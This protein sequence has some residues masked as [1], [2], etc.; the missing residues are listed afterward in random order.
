MKKAM[1]ILAAVLIAASA[2]AGK[3]LKVLAIGNSFSEDAVEQYLYELAAA[4][5]DSLVIGNAYIGGC[6]IDR[7]WSNAQSRKKEYRYRKIIGGKTVTRK[8]VDLA[9]IIR[10]DQWDIISLQQVSYLTGMPYSFGNLSNLKDYVLKTC[11]NPEVEIIWH[12]TWAYARTSG[13]NGFR[14]Y[15]KDQQIMYNNILLTTR[16]RVPRVGIR[17]VVPAGMAIQFARDKMGDVL[18]RDGFHLEKTYGRYTA[19]CTW[20][21]V[22]TRRKVTGNKYHPESIDEQTART[23]QQSAHKAVKTFRL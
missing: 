17:R 15:K 16:D 10:D 22:L 11:T 5:G 3:V 6:S 1:L 9:S 2:D 7:H 12:M 20:C 18:T 14:L 4:Q 19:A 23:A 21:E 13:H 8:S